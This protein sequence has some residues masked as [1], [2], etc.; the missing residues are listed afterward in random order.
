MKVINRIK[1]YLVAAPVFTV[2]LLSAPS[3]FCADENGT[4]IGTVVAV[5][6]SGWANRMNESVK[7]TIA[8]GDIVYAGDIIDVKYGNFVQIAL[9][10][11]PDNIIHVEGNSLIQMF[12]D[13]PTNVELSKGKVYA[14]LDNLGSA[15]GFKISTPTAIASVRGTYY[16]VKTDGVATQAITYQ[17]NV[18]VGGRHQDGEGTRGEVSVLAAQMTEVNGFSR[19]P[20]DPVVISESE[21]EEIN[22]VIRILETPKP[23]LDYQ[24]ALK[25]SKSEAPV[26]SGSKLVKSGDE[27]DSEQEQGSQVVY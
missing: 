27:D 3:G 24:E 16:Q 12:A 5:K 2:L 6:Q 26:E 9:K 20:K 18:R 21:F 11:N 25:A 4:Q 13:G 1:T 8:K 14:M 23:M 17:G 15:N 10:G 19:V 22:D 7:R